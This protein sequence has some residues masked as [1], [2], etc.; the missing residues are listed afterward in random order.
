[1][2]FNQHYTLKAQ[3]LPI[4]QQPEL[5]V[6]VHGLLRTSNSMRRLGMF[7]ASAGYDV[8][9]YAYHSARSPIEKL[10]EDYLQF[11][12]K[13]IMQYPQHRLSF[14]THSLGGI[15]TRQ[16]LSWLSASQ[17]SRCVSLVMLA[18]PNR[19]SFKAKWV[20]KIPM[21][22]KLIKPLAELSSDA[23]AYVQRVAIPAQVK[24]GIIAG[25]FDTS[26][27][28]SLASLDGM[29]DFVVINSAHSFMM[30]NPSARKAILHFLQNGK[31]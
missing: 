9:A 13:I 28:P 21:A 4:S 2:K 11:L 3:C 24:I 29:H 15:L 18:P 31:F 5:V 10:S 27:R 16:A 8:V 19:G 14:V 17:L 30:N 7:L 25:R 23:Q 6:L 26:V 22:A 1:M 12:Q 20:A